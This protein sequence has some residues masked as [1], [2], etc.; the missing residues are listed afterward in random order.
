MTTT[1]AATPSSSEDK[2]TNVV[3]T[4]SPSTLSPS[5][6]AADT[7]TRFYSA[8]NAAD[9]D[10]AVLNMAPD[11]EY[12]D[13][14]YEKPFMGKENVREYF[15]KAARVLGP[16]VKFVVDGLSPAEDGSAVGV[17][18]HCELDDGTPLPNSRGCSFYELRD[19]GAVIFRARDFVE[20]S[21]KPGA[22]TL[23]LLRAV[24]PLVRLA[25]RFEN[26][27][28]DDDGGSGC[29]EKGEGPSSSSSGSGVGGGD[30]LAFRSS[31]SSSSSGH[32]DSPSPCP[33]SSSA[34]SSIVGSL[35][36]GRGGEEGGKTKDGNGMSLTFAFASGSSSSSDSSAPSSFSPS[37]SS[38][39]GSGI[40]SSL[41]SLSIFG[42]GDG[43]D[44]SGIS[45][46]TSN[47]SRSLSIPSPPPLKPSLTINSALVWL[48]YVAYL[49]FV[50]FSRD[51]P[52][53]PVLETLP[54]VLT[55]II[56]ESWTFYY[57]VPIFNLIADA[58]SLPVSFF[59][60][61]AKNSEP[62]E[63]T[64]LKKNSTLFSNKKNVLQN[65]K[66][67]GS[68]TCR[69]TRCPRPSLTL[70]TRGL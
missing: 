56:H 33:S 70:P 57:F 49:S 8:W 24:L 40:I 48:F 69:N 30:S 45:S 32:L 29:G 51:L 20:P 9:P 41:T 7:V 31:S 65:R 19:S 66:P 46:N 42:G 59:F 17:K 34:V 18:W 16:A 64:K 28:K 58:A 47:S 11:V 52:G 36:G 63:S 22:A 12:W 2:S 21:V 23:Y 50:F 10:G 3:S 54:E 43:N 14:I 53:S 67:C 27:E 4:S 15:A 60:L 25:A 55:E 39:D 44:S 5:A 61:V 37:N 35:S 13:T 26:K 6:R 1:A 62:S 68:R 38:G